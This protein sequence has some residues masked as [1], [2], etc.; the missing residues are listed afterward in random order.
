MPS[1]PDLVAHKP[2]FHRNEAWKQPVRC[3]TGAAGTLASS[4]ENGDTAGGVV[5]ATGDRILVKNQAAAEENGIYLVAASGAPTRDY[6]FDVAAEVVGAIVYVVEGTLAGTLWR[7]TNATAPE[8]EVDDITWAIY[9]ASPPALDELTDVTITAPVAGQ[10]IR[11]DGAEW[12]NVVP[13]W[14]G[15]LLVADG[16]AGPE[17]ITPTSYVEEADAHT[18]TSGT[19]EDIPDVST[20]I[21]LQRTSHIAAWLNTQVSGSGVCVIG[22]AVNLNGSDHDEVQHAIAG[23]D[24]GVLSVVHRTATELAPGTYTV[25][26]RMRRVSGAS[27][28]SVNRADLLVMSM[29]HSGPV[30]LTTEDETDLIYAD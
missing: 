27:T 9:T 20:T 23:S 19:L 21:T 24:A 6:D 17:G 4:F 12:V 28:P 8:L 1:P 15:E 13:P 29:G 14:T 11:Y 16:Q 5:L 10:V 30:M 18:T 2:H 3:A 22:V 7:C 25:K 26:G